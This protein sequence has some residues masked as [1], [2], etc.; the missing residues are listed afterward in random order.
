MAGRRTK[1]KDILNAALEMKK[2][3]GQP[4]ITDDGMQLK[5]RDIILSV[6]GSMPYMSNGIVTMGKIIQ[7]KYAG[8]GQ[9]DTSSIWIYVRDVTEKQSTPEWI[10]FNA[11]LDKYE[12]GAF[13]NV[14]T[15]NE[16][17]GNIAPIISERPI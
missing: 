13:N 9:S 8:F 14:K 11:W 3:Y 17:G 10:S 15:E 16:N 2:S 1:T 12:S 4:I 7:F 6:N 5:Y